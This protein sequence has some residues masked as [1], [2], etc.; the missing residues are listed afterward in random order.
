MSA[1]PMDIL[2]D[3]LD[4]LDRFALKACSLVCQHF[5]QSTQKLLFSHLVLSAWNW[6][7]QC[8]FLLRHENTSRFSMIEKVTVE[9]DE[10]PVWDQDEKPDELISLLVKLGPQIEA[11]CINGLLLGDSPMLGSR[12]GTRWSDMSTILK[13]CLLQHV[14]PG[15]KSLQL[16]EIGDAPLPLILCSCP[17]LRH[18]HIGAQ[19]VGCSENILDE[20][21]SGPYPNIVSLT[22]EPFNSYDLDEK[23]SLTHFIKS[24][25]DQISSLTLV[26]PW[27]GWISPDLAFLEPFISIWA[28]LRHLIFGIKL[29]NTI[30]NE[31]PT[32]FVPRHLLP[33]SNFSQLETVTIPM[34]IHTSSQATSKYWDC[35]FNWL[36][37]VVTFA[38]IPTSLKA[39]R[40]YILPQLNRLQDFGPSPSSLDQ[41]QDRFNFH[42]DF[43]VPF[44]VESGKIEMVFG[45][46]RSTFPSWNDV[47]KL[48]CRVE[49]Y[50]PVSCE[51]E[52][53]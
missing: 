36:N 41:V 3:I 8:H 23:S 16:H 17:R 13:D 31:L 18:L 51:V 4:C 40:F 19:Y 37:A 12:D 29:Y 33:L 48:N 35:W 38:P 14:I 27:L 28:N 9:L 24:A 44:S 22:L 10:L 34:H 49:V 2:L 39:L 50:R 43:I 46:A 20:L 42:L 15:V 21:Q 47:G 53:E 7:V 30:A 1:L 45:F 25:G 6:E 5:H 11:L 26:A 52:L 32:Q